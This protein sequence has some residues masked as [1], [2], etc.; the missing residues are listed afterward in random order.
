MGRKSGRPQRDQERA[1]FRAGIDRVRPTHRHNWQPGYNTFAQDAVVTAHNRTNP[2]PAKRIARRYL[3][4]EIPRLAKLSEVDVGNQEVFSEKDSFSQLGEDIFTFQNFMNVRRDDA[5]ILEVGAFDGVTYSNTLALELYNHCKCVLIEPSPI[6]VRKIF[7]SRPNASIHQM[8]VSLGYSM[9]EF[10][11]HSALGGITDNLSN[12][13]IQTWGLAKSD[14]YKVPTIPL[15]TVLEMNNIQ[16][17]DFISID[18]QGG[19]LEV[20]SSM[21]WNIPVGTFCVELEGQDT[22]RDAACR[23]ILQGMGYEFN[24]RLHIS[25][26][27]HSK[28]Y[29][30]NAMIFDASVRLPFESFTLKHFVPPWVQTL[31]ENFY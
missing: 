22:R 17:I 21:N 15:S 6:N 27:W 16:Y 1:A 7:G 19:E 14:R 10:L 3:G 8:A 11:G 24:R 30:R 20:L 5:V 9:T 2:L 25:E 31:R 4:W 26:F 29:E 28:N 13:Y 23:G 12:Q 18:V